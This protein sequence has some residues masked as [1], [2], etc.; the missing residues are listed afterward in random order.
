[1][2]ES[3][4]LL[5]AH[6]RLPPII[7]ALLLALSLGGCSAVRTG[8]NN[9]PTLTYWWLDRYFDFTD[10]QSVR[11]RQDLAQVHAWHRAQELSQIDHFLQQLQHLAKDS[12]SPNQLCT[13]YTQAQT[14]ALAPLERL[15]PSI[16]AITTTLDEAQLLHMQAEFARRETK[17]RAEWMEGDAGARLE[18]R[19]NRWMDWLESLYGPMDE[20]QILALKE[21]LER[22]VF[23][24]NRQYREIRR[25]HDDALQTLKTIRQGSLQTDQAQAALAG[26]L[27]RSVRA[28]EPAHRRYAEQLRR[29]ACVAIADLHNQASA[30]QRKRLVESL[31]RYRDDA[32]ALAPATPASTPTAAT[33]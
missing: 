1:M 32:R 12:V 13:A 28:P 15:I 10:A 18:R 9:A 17:W 24:P 19:L 30:A 16:A 3:L 22:S 8:Y 5:Q 7:G 25:R 26:V 6:P 2:L 27:E 4:K 33:R 20:S 14:R 29:E 11:L 23:D 21:H 31:Q